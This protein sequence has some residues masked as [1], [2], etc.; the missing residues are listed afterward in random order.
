MLAGEQAVDTASDLE[1]ERAQERLG[2]RPGTRPVRRAL[3]DERRGAH[4]ARSARSISGTGTV[5]STASMIE[6]APT[7]AARAS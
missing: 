4:A 3:P 6:S 5:S 7:S 1:V 2:Q